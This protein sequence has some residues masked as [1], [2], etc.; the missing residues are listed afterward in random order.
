MEE[1][2]TDGM[3]MEYNDS[4]MCSC[5][6]RTVQSKVR[7]DTHCATGAHHAHQ[8]VQLEQGWAY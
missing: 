6:H 1:D 2:S 3:L 8:A 7:V 5:K 4:N